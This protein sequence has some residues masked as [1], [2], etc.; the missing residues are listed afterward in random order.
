MR[1]STILICL[2][3]VFALAMLVETTTAGDRVAVPPAAPAVAAAPEVEAGPVRQLVRERS[4]RVER[5]SV[6]PVC[7]PNGC[8]TVV[9]RTVE[10]RQVGERA[11]GGLISRFRS[12]RGSGRFFSRSRTQSLGCCK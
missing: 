6:E 7:G 9:S 5:R 1:L 8:E 12:R 10:R 3:G 4:V 2:A 11:G